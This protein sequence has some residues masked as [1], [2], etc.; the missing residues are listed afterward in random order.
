M[1]A[2]NMNFKQPS[3]LRNMLLAFL[4]FGLFM[5]LVFP[6]FAHFFVEWKPGMFFWFALSCVIA[7]I[8]IGLF[9]FWLL[10]RMLLRRFERIGVVAKAISH[11]DI[12]A[13]CSL[14]SHDFVGEMS[15]SFNTMTANLRSMVQQISEVSD[16]MHHASGVMVDEANKTQQGVDLQKNDTQKM[17]QAV[18]LMRQS[19]A[20]V[21]EQAQD[22]LAAV[23][24]TDQEARKGFERVE[25]SVMIIEQLALQV[26]AA[27]EVIKQLDQD[28]ANIAKVIGVIKSIAEQTN[29]LALN[30][31]IEAAR[32]GE[33]G[34]GFAVVADEVRVL[35][36]R[37]QESTREI[38]SSIAH[39]IDVSKKAV[40][41]MDEGREQARSSVVHAH[42]AGET[43][44]FIQQSVATIYQKNSNI[45]ESTLQQS[46]QADLVEKNLQRVSQTSDQVD[47]GTH[48]TLAASNKVG[49][50]SDH[51]SQL[52]G[53]F[54]LHSK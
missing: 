8:S 23:K 1:S 33:N 10:N 5:G 18:N 52:V 40:Q 30:A 45:V 19:L 25:D 2:I 49:R 6:L 3:I 4:G 50:L 7:G 20:K 13:K 39:L 16:Q 54:K 11:N 22:A 42:Q 38:E 9:N 43:L 41:V 28:A 14:Q 31:A 24:T 21:S 15:A 34:R 17:V 44:S 27:S 29:L 51:L 12:S 36:S 37:T 47:Q 48:N 46:Q 32:A 26:E 35:A 53:M